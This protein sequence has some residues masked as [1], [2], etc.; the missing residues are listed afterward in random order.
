MLLKMAAAA[1]QSAAKECEHIK[2]ESLS[3]SLHLRRLLDSEVNRLQSATSLYAKYMSAL[4][5]EGQIEGEL[6]EGE[7]LENL[8]YFQAKC[9]ELAVGKLREQGTSVREMTEVFFQLYMLGKFR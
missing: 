7:R 8:E 9:K 6:E 5:L 3:L 4:V 2:T 1:L